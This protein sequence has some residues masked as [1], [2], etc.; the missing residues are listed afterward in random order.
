[1][2]KKLL[3]KYGGDEYLKVPENIV[4][5]DEYVEYTPNGEITETI[6]N[7]EKKSK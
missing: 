1:M 6:T 7:T 2:K 5:N 4:E 3:E